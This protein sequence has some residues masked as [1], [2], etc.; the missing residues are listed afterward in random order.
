MSK[1]SRKHLNT[2]ISKVLQIGSEWLGLQRTAGNV[3]YILYRQGLFSADGLSAKE[4]SEMTGLSQ[5]TVSS[6]CSS[7]ES[8]DIITRRT[9][10]NQSHRGRKKSVYVMAM[11]LDDLLRKGIQRNLDQ[12]NKVSKN[13]DEILVNMNLEDSS[14][15]ALLAKVADEINLFLVT[16]H[17]E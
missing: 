8:L 9:D 14:S 12:V 2:Q 17:Y 10:N 16:P 15:I 1:K 4:L 7:L 3:L 11:G 5:S 13:I 6:V